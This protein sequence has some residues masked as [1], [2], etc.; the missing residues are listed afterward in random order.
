MDIL[1]R[2]QKFNT[3]SHLIWHLLSKRQ[4]MW[5][6]VSNFVAFL[7]NLNFIIVVKL[8]FFV[9]FLEELRIP[10][11]PFEINWPLELL[12][13]TWISTLEQ[14]LGSLHLHSFCISWILNL[15][16]FAFLLQDELIIRVNLLSRYLAYLKIYNNKICMNLLEIRIK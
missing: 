15:F 1:K 9:H 11:S 13:S 3:I 6:I 5:E 4:I 10:K 7:E 12:C 2:P 14:T 16:S 8:N